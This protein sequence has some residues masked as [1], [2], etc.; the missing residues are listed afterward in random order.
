MNKKLLKLVTGYVDCSDAIQK[1][2]IKN[3]QE[4]EAQGEDLT[5]TD[6][7]YETIQDIGYKIE[8]DI[9]KEY[10]EEILAEVKKEEKKKQNK[11]QLETL[12]ELIFSGIGIAIVV[13]ILVN[14]IFDVIS[15]KI[16][17]DYKL[18]AGIVIVACIF[19][20]GMIIFRKAISLIEQ[21]LND[22]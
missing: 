21:I 13:G 17:C 6:F 19:F 1:A 12:K 9:R 10:K 4:A 8:E 5:E 15:N 7:K 2:Y 14:Q 18:K 22:K 20:L 16:V 3:K 11:R